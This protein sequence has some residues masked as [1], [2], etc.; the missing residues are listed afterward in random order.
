[1][2]NHS[3]IGSSEDGQF[4]LSETCRVY[5][6]DLRSAT[7]LNSPTQESS[8]YSTSLSYLHFLHR[9]VTKSSLKLLLVF[10][11]YTE[12]NSQLLLQATKE[13]D[14]KNHNKT[15]HNVMEIMKDDGQ[16]AEIMTYVMTLFNKTLNAIPDQD[17][18]YDITDSL[19]VQGMEKVTQRLTGRSGTDLD[20]MEQIRIYEFALKH[21][22]GEEDIP[23]QQKQSLR[24]ARRSMDPSA[25]DRKSM[26]SLR[27]TPEWGNDVNKRVSL[28]PKLGST[29]EEQLSSSSGNEDGLTAQRRRRE[30]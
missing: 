4:N 16:D 11:E 17:S 22:D 27:T 12:T 28:D 9:L 18:F 29:L 6:P 19:E 21:E 23:M 13:V 7:L 10:V 30:R 2:C 5:S 26:R 25:T 3:K 14:G 20:L 8:F 15:W 24:K 1:M